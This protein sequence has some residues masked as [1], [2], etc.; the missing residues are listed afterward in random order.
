PVPWIAPDEMVYGLL[1]HNLYTH[2]SLTILGGP[3]PFYS[4]LVP[5]FVGLPLS[6]ADF[7]FGY[8]LLKVL[9]AAAMSLAAV[10]VFLWGRSLVSTRWAL[11]AAA[12]TLALPGLVYS[13]LVMT[14]V[15]FYPLLV[16]AAWAMARAIERPTPARQA[17]LVAAV[18]C[19]A[20][21]RLQAIVL[22]P[23]FATALG[24]DSLLARSRRLPTRLAPSLVGMGLLVAGWLAWRLGSSDSVLGGYEVVAHSSY[25]VGRAARFVVYHAGSLAMLSGLVPLCAL[26]LLLLAGARRGEPDPRRR[27]FLATT[28][29]IAAWIV[30]EVGIFAS[31]YVGQL[32]ERDLIGLAPLPFLAFVLWL[33]R[34]APRGYWST[35][36]VCVAVA[37]PLAVLPLG[38]LVTPAAPPDAPTVAPLWDIVAAT[39]LHAFEVGFYAVLAVVLALFALVPR[40]AIS[41]LPALLVAAL[42]AASVQASREAVDQA[43]LRRTMF[44]GADPAWIDR[45]ADGPVAF[46][47]VPG[48]DWTGV[49]QTIFWNRKI[50]RVYDLGGVQVT[51]PLP[52]RRLDF[53]P[54]GRLLVGGRVATPRYVVAPV[55][56]IQGAPFFSFAGEVVTDVERPGSR[57]GNL[58][59]WKL[60]QPPRAISQLT[61]LLPQ[62]DIYPGGDGRLV[63][64]G[65]P[66]GV[67]QLTL[68]VKQEQRLTILR[69]GKV[70]RKLTFLHPAPNEPW[71]A[72]IPTV[73]PPGGRRGRSAC[74]LDVR[75]TGL[76]G[77]TVF[78]FQPRG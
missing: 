76:L 44:L 8:G 68:L 48:A 57:L 35:A 2:G 11:V 33:E 49:W 19:A 66:Q 42:A 46:L 75:P 59:L 6:L 78:Q 13:G 14:E 36:A 37:A 15:L 51:G 10:P 12:L 65:C 62:G 74:T 77:T 3:T 40:R 53:A 54:G 60:T 31:R 41:L 58:A 73:P 34:G 7:A 17:L 43:R 52:Q 63:V 18:A 45:A 39:S 20:L 47:F 26:L 29:S 55:G 56:A 5:A 69:N 9:Q 28:V 23:A 72:E 22:L 27:A 32:A 61:G 50:D 21:A 67:F 16:L 70:I 25:S 30:V 1:G 71:R 38:R 64:Y 4:L 24:L